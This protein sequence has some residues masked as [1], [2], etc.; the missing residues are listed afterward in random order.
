LKVYIV[1]EYDNDCPIGPDGDEAFYQWEDI[2]E[3]FDSRE[4]A[5]QFQ[6][7]DSFTYRI[8]EYDVK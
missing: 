1:T 4:K 2:K 6:N 5:E 3:V 8:H 7:G